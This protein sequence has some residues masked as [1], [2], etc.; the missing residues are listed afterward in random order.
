[1][2]WSVSPPCKL[3]NSEDCSTF[4]TRN[5]YAVWTPLIVSVTVTVDV[6]ESVIETGYGPNHGCVEGEEDV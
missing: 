2:K 6:K 5:A 4:P 3:K 1:M